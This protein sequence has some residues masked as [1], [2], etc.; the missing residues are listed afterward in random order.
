[1]ENEGVDGLYLPP[2]VVSLKISALFLSAHLKEEQ[3]FADV[4]GHLSTGMNYRTG[5]STHRRSSSALYGMNF[6]FARSSQSIGKSARSAQQLSRDL[7]AGVDVETNAARLS[8]AIPT[9]ADSAEKG[10]PR[11][12]LFSSPQFI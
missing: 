12:N 3:G 4:R 10:L 9:L 8:D 7:L 6:G 5:T 11:S 2:V 1:M